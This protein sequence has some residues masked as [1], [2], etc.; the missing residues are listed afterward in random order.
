M[1]NLAIGG[2]V[3]GALILG[4]A[5]GAIVVGRVASRGISL[6]TRGRPVDLATH[7][8][9]AAK[10]RLGETGPVIEHE[11]LLIDG[12]V[13]SVGA[14]AARE[15]SPGSSADKAL[16]SAKL[17][18]AVYPSRS[19]QTAQVATVLDSVSTDGPVFN[20]GLLRRLAGK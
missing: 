6:L 18:R 16:R 11:E 8:S 10:L 3:L 15:R 1:K 12:S 13:L 19:D 17:Y 14:L 9:M 7:V 4:F 5:A 20:E 2:L